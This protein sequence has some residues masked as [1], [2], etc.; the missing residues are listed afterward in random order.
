MDERVDHGEFQAKDQKREMQREG[1]CFGV[2]QILKYW[3]SKGI[4]VNIREFGSI[5]FVGPPLSLRGYTWQ[6]LPT[7]CQQPPVLGQSV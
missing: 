3:S 4:L 6:M 2:G 1:V 7:K 5:I